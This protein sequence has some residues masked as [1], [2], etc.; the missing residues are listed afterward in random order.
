MDSLAR[1]LQGINANLTTLAS[2]ME[3]VEARVVS[4]PTSPSTPPAPGKPSSFLER[5]VEGDSEEVLRGAVQDELKRGIAPY[6]TVLLSDRQRESLTRQQ[7]RFDERY[8]EGKWNEVLAPRIEHALKTTPEH[9]RASDDYL[10]N[11]VAAIKGNPEVEPALDT[12]REAKVRADR[13]RPPAPPQFVGAGRPRLRPGETGPELTEDD[14]AFFAGLKQAGVA[15]SEK[16]YQR[17]RSLPREFDA[18]V[19]AMHEKG[20]PVPG[21]TPPASRPN[22]PTPPG[23]TA[24]VGA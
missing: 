5:F 13:E 9:L 18:R 10:S 21:D 8:G 22:G 20:I 1:A 24:P 16:D 23:S 14:R 15:W 7:T 3:A 17:S 4:P 12:A 19:T 6:L 2:R 11:L